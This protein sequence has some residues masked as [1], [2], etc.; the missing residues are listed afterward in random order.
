MCPGLVE[1]GT[2]RY[3]AEVETDDRAAASGLGAADERVAADP[4]HRLPLAVDP[5]LGRPNSK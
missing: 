1:Y 5:Y 4:A 3:V 2:S